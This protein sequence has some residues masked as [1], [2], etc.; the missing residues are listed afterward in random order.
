ML[1]QHLP[2]LP[3]ANSVEVATGIRLLLASKLLQVFVGTYMKEKKVGKENNKKRTPR[4]CTYPSLREARK[5]EETCVRNETP[6]P[7]RCKNW[8]CLLA[9]FMAIS[10]KVA[11]S[12]LQPCTINFTIIIS[13]ILWNNLEL[14]FM[15]L[16]P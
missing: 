9:P 3:A 1:L 14:Y 10:L 2:V 15:R 4:Q 11:T 16:K 7:A 6:R 5:E 8:R 13:I 12:D